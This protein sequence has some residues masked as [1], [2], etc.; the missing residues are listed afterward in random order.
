[1]V[2]PYPLGRQPAALLAQD[3]ALAEATH[4][5]GFADRPHLQLSF[6]GPSVT[7]GATWPSI[8]ALAFPYHAYPPAPRP[9]LNCIGLGV[10]FLMDEMLEH[11][12]AYRHGR[13]E[14]ALCSAATLA[15]RAAVAVAAT[16]LPGP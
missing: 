6:Q 13:S 11:G 9:G 10:N 15:I 3:M 2:L 14:L 12:S 5:M 1:M 4:A 16:T 8:K 7:P